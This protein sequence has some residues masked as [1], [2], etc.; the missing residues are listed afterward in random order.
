MTRRIRLSKDREAAEHIA[1][2]MYSCL[3]KLSK[4]E[5]K[6]RIK[7]IQKVK[8]GRRSSPKPSSTRASFQKRSQALT[9]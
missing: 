6:A 1:E 5:Q 2:I 8:V 3:Q 4:E 9:A 7:A